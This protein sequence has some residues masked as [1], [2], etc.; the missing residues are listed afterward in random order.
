MASTQAESAAI[1]VIRMRTRLTDAD[2]EKSD[3]GPSYLLPCHPSL[4]LLSTFI[5]KPSFA[6]DIHVASPPSLSLPLHLLLHPAPPLAPPPAPT[7]TTAPDL[8]SASALALDP[9]LHR[10]QN[11]NAI[12][13]AV[14][15]CPCLAD[16]LYVCRNFSPP[17]LRQKRT[18]SSAHALTRY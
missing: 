13:P 6:I 5:E 7:S 14:H 18:H 16:N 15:T 10:N 12:T 11:T 3:P 4:R 1:L 9:P 17:S 8:A 2:D